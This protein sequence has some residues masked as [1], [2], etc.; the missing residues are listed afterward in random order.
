MVFNGTELYHYFKP[1]Y[2]GVV[3]DRSLTFKNHLEQLSQK[4]RINV[5]LIQMLAGTEC[6]ASTS[7]LR[8]SKF[9]HVFSTMNYS[10]PIWY[11]RAHVNKVD[12]H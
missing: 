5:N 2:L 8:N 1:K 9:S 12:V 3:L 7:T 10:S 4:R 11:N 6:G